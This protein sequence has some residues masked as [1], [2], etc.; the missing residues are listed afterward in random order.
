ML[1]LNLW[2]H[3]AARYIWYLSLHNQLVIQS[4]KLQQYLREKNLGTTDYADLGRTRVNISL[5]LLDLINQ[6]PEGEKSA[7]PGKLPGIS[8]QSL[9]RQVLF[10]LAVGKVF[11]F[12]YI[13]TLWQSGGLTFEGFL[14]TMGIVFPFLPLTCPY[15]IR[16]CCCTAM[17]TRQP[18]S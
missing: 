14:G 4:G 10:L 3:G 17:I 18:I 9:K 13:F 1:L 8:E 12:L 6:M 11:L 15:Y 7:V 2:L 5:A 16:I